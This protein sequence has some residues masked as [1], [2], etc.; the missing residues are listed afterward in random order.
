MKNNFDTNQMGTITQQFNNSTIDTET[1]QRIT[2]LRFLL[3]ILV[4]FIHN[5][6]TVETVSNVQKFITSGESPFIFVENVFSRWIKIFI[7]RGIAQGAVPCFLLFSAFLQAKKDDR[8]PTLLKKRA[9]SLLLPYIIWVVILYGSFYSVFKLVMI[10]FAPQLLV[11]PENN[12]LSWTI[13][14]WIH[15]IFGYNPVY[16][17]EPEFAGQ[18]WFIR[19]LMILV[20]V[21]PVIKYLIKKLP[22]GFLFFVIIIY[23]VN[24]RVFFVENVAFFSYVMGFYWAYYDVHLFKCV[25]RINWK[26]I[27]TVFI[28]TVFFKYSFEEFSDDTVLNR[29][30]NI[31]ACILLL[32]ISFLIVNNN[33]VYSI[34][35]Y[36]AGFSFFLFAIHTPLLNIALSKVWIR[37]FPI[38]NEFLN[39]C[40]YFIPTFMTIAI[41]TGLG[42]FLRKICPPLFRVLNG[43]R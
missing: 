32:K 34:S 37:F 4:V 23:T 22:Y 13:L 30:I 12:M 10:K 36:L 14:D 33:K 3:I 5:T 31:I 15:K 43:G 6:Y 28:L 27:L 20:F 42:I 25:D 35:K 9:K 7:S 16:L 11:N 2:S 38:K 1:S 39:L 21:S 17:Y 24:V 18:F 8:Y 29:L 19:D 40:Q 26:E 41:G